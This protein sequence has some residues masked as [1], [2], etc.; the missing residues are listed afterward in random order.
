MGDR[1]TAALES[2]ES[3]ESLEL[4]TTSTDTL[5]RFWCASRSPVI[6]PILPAWWWETVGDEGAGFAQPTRNPAAG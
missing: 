5:A 4:E 1:W 6:R 2:L 3:L